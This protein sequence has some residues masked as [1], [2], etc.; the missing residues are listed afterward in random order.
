MTN[1][2]IV[3]EERMKLMNDGIIGTTGKTLTIEKEG[4]KCK[5]DEPE[6]IHTYKAWQ[7]LGYQVRRG[8]KATATFM[9]WKHTVK[10]A[11]EEKDVDME[12]MFKTKA[13][14]FTANQV[15]QIKKS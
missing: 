14:F 7:S 5:V 9:I 1:E 10:K 11:K 8:Q 13:F 12:K 3:F 6:V 2:Q 15:E 4:K